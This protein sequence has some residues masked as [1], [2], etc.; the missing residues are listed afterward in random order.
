MFSG[1][2]RPEE[3]DEEEEEEED[4]DVEEVEE[5]EEDLVQAGTGGSSVAKETW[6]LPSLIPP[7]G[8]AG[9]GPGEDT[10]SSSKEKGIGC[11]IKGKPL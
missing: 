7:G 9:G 5:V 8:A 10:V 4:E 11:P 1:L 6:N 2:E 3:E